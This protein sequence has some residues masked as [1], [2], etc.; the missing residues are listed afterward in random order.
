[1]LED[2][3]V[4]AVGG[5]P[6]VPG[7]DLALLEADEVELPLGEAV[8]AIGTGLRVREGTV[9]ALDRPDSAPEVGRRAVVPVVRAGRHAHPLPGGERHAPT[10]ASSSPGATIP[11]S[12]RIV[13]IAKS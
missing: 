9:P 11:F 2:V 5:A 4:D 1:M 13:S 6:R 10:L 7:P 12:A 8:G 3:G